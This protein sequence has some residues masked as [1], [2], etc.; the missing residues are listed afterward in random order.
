MFCSLFNPVSESGTP[1][2]ASG[3]FLSVICGLG[4][5]ADCIRSIKVENPDSPDPWDLG[6]FISRYP[7][8]ADR[9]GALPP[10]DARLAALG[11]AARELLSLGST[12][13]M[14]ERHARKKDPAELEAAVLAEQEQIGV[15]EDILNSK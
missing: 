14:L 4:E 9:I 15:L 6:V 13:V 10:G 2:N 7:D 12:K 11:P 3:T 1:S 8:L 5:D